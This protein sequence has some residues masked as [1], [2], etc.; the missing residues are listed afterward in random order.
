MVVLK[1]LAATGGE[2]TL[3]WDEGGVMSDST[4]R[5]VELERLKIEEANYFLDREKF[6]FEQTRYFRDNRFLNRNFG[7]IVTTI[8]SVA[9]IVVSYLQLTISS[10]TAKSQIDTEKLKTTDSS[11]LNL[12]SSC[13]QANTTQTPRM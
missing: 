6:K 3:R 5:Q 12:P 2:G 11:I 7:V 4:L 1:G 10:N 13:L 8:V 9:A